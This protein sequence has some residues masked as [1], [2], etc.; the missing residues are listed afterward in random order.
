VPGPVDI[1]DSARHKLCAKCRR[2]FERGDGE[3]VPVERMRLFEGMFR[4]AKTLAG[5]EPKRVFICHGCLRRRRIIS[6]AIWLAFVAAV[7]FALIHGYLTDGR[8]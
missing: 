4:L 1:P 8:L 3:E 5:L 6:A 7:A 2:W